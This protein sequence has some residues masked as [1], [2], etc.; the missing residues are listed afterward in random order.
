[1][2]WS[3]PNTP[4]PEIDTWPKQGVRVPKPVHKAVAEPARSLRGGKYGLLG[5]LWPVAI[6]EVFKL[7][8]KELYRRATALRAKQEGRVLTPADIIPSPGGTDS[9]EKVKRGRK[10]NLKLAR[11]VDAALRSARKPKRPKP[12]PRRPGGRVRPK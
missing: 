12:S 11:D 6:A 10:G 5:Y 2:E 9:P 8:R 4:L 7:D 1:M 3:D